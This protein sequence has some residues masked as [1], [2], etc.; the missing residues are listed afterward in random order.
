MARQAALARAPIA[1]PPQSHARV[2]PCP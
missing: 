2:C 1:R